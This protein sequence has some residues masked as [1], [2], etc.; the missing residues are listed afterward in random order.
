MAADHPDRDDEAPH[1]PADESDE[2][3]SGG[4]GPT[5]Q[6]F[7]APPPPDEDASADEGPAAPGSRPSE[8]SAETEI[9]PVAPDLSRDRVGPGS[10]GILPPV[11]GI[12]GT[13][14]WSARAPVRTPDIAEDEHDWAEPPRGLLVPILVAVCVLLLV[15]LLGLGS[16][17]IFASR[18]SGTP[19]TTP[20]VQNATVPATTAAQTTTITTTPPPTELPLPNVR[21]LDYETAA[22][23]LTKL[24]FIPVRRDEIDGEVPA[25]KVVGTDPPV[26]T[27]V[28][29]GTRINIIVSLGLPVQSS[30][31]V[32]PSPT[33]S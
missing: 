11:D 9:R 23:E 17:L 20:T 24:G 32:S 29:T 27:P 10:T 3:G 14:R 16:W 1:T 33:R 30:P 19:A 2:S 22:A 13:P 8:P 18:P 5:A 6:R 21:G 28:L 31:A 4:E 7:P 12:P 25:G 26:G 15:A